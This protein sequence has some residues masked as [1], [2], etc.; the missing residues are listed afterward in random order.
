M[1]SRQKFIAFM[2]RITGKPPLIQLGEAY[3]WRIHGVLVTLW[4][5]PGNI[6]IYHCRNALSDYLDDTS[7]SRWH[8]SFYHFQQEACREH[9]TNLSWRYH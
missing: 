5:V 9:L 3:S 4:I 6:K 7:N 1:T 8:T 2:L